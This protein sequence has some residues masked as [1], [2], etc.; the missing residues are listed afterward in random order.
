MRVSLEWLREYIAIPFSAQE[1]AERLTMAGIAV[2]EVEYMG[3]KYRGVLVGEIRELTPHPHADN[4]IIS[5]VYLGN[6]ENVIITGAKNLKV[7]DKVPVATPGSVLPNGTRIEETDFRGV[8]SSGML[9]S[10]MELGLARESSGI[11]TLPADSRVGAEIAEVLGLDDEILVLELTANRADCYGLLGVAREVSAMTGEPIKMPDLSVAE[12]ADAMIEDLAC[13]EVID[14]DLCPRYAARV[15]TDIKMGDSPLWMRRRL[16]AAGIRPISNI[17]DL[18]N[19]VMLELNQPLHAFDLERISGGKVFIRRARPDERLTTLDDIDR[20]LK[21]EQLLIADQEQGHCIAGV[22]GGC[23][24]EVSDRTQTV[25]LESAYFLPVSIR[26]TAASLA[27]RTEA[28]LRFGKAGIDPAG[29]V[30]ALDRTAHLAVK[31][32]IGRI[33]RGVIDKYPEPI[34]QRKITARIS[35]INNLLGTDISCDDV[36]GYLERLGLLIE[37]KDK[38]QFTVTAPTRRPDLENQADLAEE[39]ARLHGYDN[40]PVKFSSSNMVGRRTTRQL[41][42]KNIREMLMG[43]GLTEIMTYSFHGESL[44]DRM[45]LTANDPLRQTVK[46]WVPLSEEGSIMRTTLLGGL[47]QTLEY[48][49]KRRQNDVSFFE[50][51]RVYH[52]VQDEELPMEPLHLSGGL[53]GQVAEVGWNQP[54]RKAD[55]YDAKGIIEALLGR[56]GVLRLG[57]TKGYHPLLHP[58]RSAHVTVDTKFAGAVGEIHPRVA[59]EF[60]LT[61]PVVLFELNLEAILPAAGQIDV[62]Y[63]PL[64]RYPGMTRDMALL[65]PEETKAAQIEEVV[66]VTAGGLLEEIFLFDLYAGENIPEGFRSLAYSLYFRAEDRTLLEDETNTLMDKI[67]SE[68][69]KRFNAELR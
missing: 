2:E 9:C 64:P 48:N 63:K 22:M 10:E 21:T 7:G 40:I 20:Q 49:A 53:M 69:S 57:F 6:K 56:L 28:S 67:F 17:V 25:F 32:G 59:K 36:F 55:F 33:A 1:L 4:L 11:M 62:V 8:L 30:M 38:D 29:T 34:Q 58:G 47:L 44:L 31:L 41:Q 27:M 3:E 24:S 12:E 39:V 60:G 52:P 54:H 42:E 5:R 68:L 45:G 35:R 23:I 18:T 16:L 61:E 13:V 14:P 37:S 19:Y 46:M 50:L 66:R 51:A 15:L 26:R 43:F 65:V